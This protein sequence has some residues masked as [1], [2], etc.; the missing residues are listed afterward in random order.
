MS[1]NLIS[2]INSSL[3][4][5]SRAERQVGDDTGRAEEPTGAAG[6]VGAASG[7]DPRSASAFP[8]LTT[9]AVAQFLKVPGRV[10]ALAFFVLVF[11]AAWSSGVGLFE[12]VVSG[13]VE[14]GTLSRKRAAWLAGSA[15]WVVSIPCALSG[16]VFEFVDGTA[17]CHERSSGAS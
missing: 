7:H 6:R 16:A 10:V 14:R 11:L 12:V 2:T 3:A 1:Q 8:R 15:I 9:L 13:L 5:L 17:G 4:D